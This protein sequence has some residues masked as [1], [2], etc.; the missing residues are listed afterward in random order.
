VFSIDT[1]RVYL[2][3]H[4]AG[5]DAA[6]DLGVS[7]PDLWAGVIPITANAEKFVTLYHENA[8]YV[9]WYFVVGD[10]D[11]QRRDLSAV[12]W[13][14]Y[15]GRANYDVMISELLGRG[16]EH[17]YEELPRIM[18]WMKLHER[19]F[20]PKEFKVATMRSTDNFFWWA[21]LN[22]FPGHQNV[23]AF[24]WP[25]PKNTPPLTVESE[26]LA[27]NS[28]RLKPGTKS[29]RIYI[30]PNMLDLESKVNVIVDTNRIP[31]GAPQVETLLEDARTRGDRK[32]PFWYCLEFP[33]R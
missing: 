26:I 20:F 15:M 28:V 10:K 16:H 24:N 7:H 21:E 27:N 9:P 29:G 4:S 32:H 30:S 2:A 5:G 12:Q 19:N 8:R 13:D 17:F 6:W 22:D 1:D 14:R 23:N 25:P 31:L 11:G 18:E 3:G 33:P